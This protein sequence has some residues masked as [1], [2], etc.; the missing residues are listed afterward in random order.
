MP[1]TFGKATALMTGDPVPAGPADV[2]DRVLT[3][4]RG[5]A[6][7]W[8]PP[9]GGPGGVGS[10]ASGDSSITVADPSGPNVDLAVAD[11]PAVGG[12][13]VTGTPSAG[14]V[15]T[16]TSA[17]DADWQ[18]ES[19]PGTGTEDQT[20]G[21]NSGG[22]IP[23]WYTP[24]LPSQWELVWDTGH[25]GPGGMLGRLHFTSLTLGEFDD[26]YWIDSITASS[27]IGLWRYRSGAWTQL[28]N[29]NTIS[30][31]LVFGY[32]ATAY[33]GTL[34]AGATTGVVWSI[35]FTSAGALAAYTQ[36][37]GGDNAEDSF[38]GPVFNGKVYGGQHN[39]CTLW[40][41]D[42][43]TFSIVRNFEATFGNTYGDPCLITNF[44]VANGLLY[45]VVTTLDSAHQW[46]CS[47]DT[48]ETITVLW[49]GSATVGTGTILQQGGLRVWR[50]ELVAALATNTNA[51]VLAT[52]TGSGW[53]TIA[54]QGAFGAFSGK[55]LPVGDALLLCVGNNGPKFLRD[56]GLTS[57]ASLVEPYG[58][59]STA[60]GFFD[61]KIHDGYLWVSVNQ[62]TAQLWRLRLGHDHAYLSEGRSQTRAGGRQDVATVDVFTGPDTITPIST[63]SFQM[64]TTCEKRL[65]VPVTFT[66][67][68]GDAATCLVEISPDDITFYA[69]WTE[70]VPAGT[71]LDSFVRAIQIVVPQGWHTK[72]TVANATIGDGFFW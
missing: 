52:W 34:I 48:A 16:A 13:T 8:E 46:L 19:G 2:D 50:G 55:I 18:P 28:D 14:Q 6:A 26:L 1:L 44:A 61:A 5:Q 15:L 49:T 32:G 56:D 60:N 58:W 67:T 72:L 17:T 12:I 29:T 59:G 70:T 39:P 40:S 63:T 64:S 25:T 47:M 41:W 65:T 57:P 36:V 9:S 54:N 42:G 38:A 20:L 66:P 31:N 33:K 71:A 53:N 30:P 11:S 62:D 4:P 7:Q 69:V 37:Q 24:A 23:T 3:L 35:S 51:G 21:M 27:R 43:T 10:V 45:F 68:V 22:T